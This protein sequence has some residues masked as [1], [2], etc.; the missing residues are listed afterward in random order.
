[1]QTTLYKEL[2]GI[3]IPDTVPE[4]STD[5]LKKILSKLEKQVKIIR[6]FNSEFEV[7][8]YVTLEVRVPKGSY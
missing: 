1:M 4:D 2:Y 7:T 6:V 5:E 8:Q 3:P